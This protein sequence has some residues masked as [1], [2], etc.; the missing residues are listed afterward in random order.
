M[1][2]KQVLVW[3]KGL[4][5]K[6]GDKLRTGKIAA[7]LA[8]ASL[9]AIL[10]EGEEQGNTFCIHMTPEM[11]DWLTGLFTKVC[12]GVDNEEE[13]LDIYIKAGKAGIH[14]SLIQDAGLTEFGGIPTYTAVAVG[15]GDPEKIDLITGHLKLL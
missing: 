5:N 6:S 11:E 10:D 13:L 4:R 7:Q 14:R 1:K 12:V 8:H 15:P 9:K 2:T 3:T